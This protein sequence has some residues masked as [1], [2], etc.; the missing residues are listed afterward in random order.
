MAKQAAPAPTPAAPASPATA[1][2]KANAPLA[3][4]TTT[5]T[6]KWGNGEVV[7][8]FA[9]PAE[10]EATEAPAEGEKPAAEPAKPADEDKTPA[11]TPEAKEG[12]AEAE[13]K[14][15]E[16]AA[17]PAVD[18]ERRK[19]IIASL[20]AERA[21]RDMEKQI[22]DAKREA[23]EAAEKLAE[24][25]K[26]PLGKKIGLLA[27]QHGMSVEDLR[28]R[29]L[30]GAEDVAD[31]PAAPK[32]ADPEVV[33][34]KAQVAALTERLAK[35][36]EGEAQARVKQAVERVQTTLKDVDLPLVDAFDAYGRVMVKAHEAW[37]ASGK[38]GSPM[39]WVP[40]VAPLVEE[41]L[42]TEQPRAAAR[43]YP[44]ATETA[45]VDEGEAETPAPA[46]KPTP[47]IV[48]GKRT[49]AKPEAKPKSLWEN[50]RTAAEVD[51][52]IKKELGW[53]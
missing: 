43:L 23:K 27:K 10:A 45:A 14:P 42:K 28:D 50:G 49:A 46:P 53:G 31:A 29:I 1:F 18:P 19:Q 47:R 25:E 20:A 24:F 39:D 7:A 41:E 11:E 48:P 4:V 9:A 2:P 6:V 51:A 21:K 8:E 3:D 15:P 13:E 44:K 17:K 30:I 26:S 22:A 36:D 38:Q 5:E 37:N 34:L 40:D 52:Q 12:E 16:Q 33:A 32:A 35:Q